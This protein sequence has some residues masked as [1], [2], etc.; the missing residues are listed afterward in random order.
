[1]WT[2]TT[3]ATNLIVTCTTI[4]AW[5]RRAIINIQLTI[6]PLKASSTMAAVCTDQ[7]VTGSAIL[8][9]CRFAF[10]YVHCAIAAG[11]SFQ[12]VTSVTVAY[13]LASSIVA[14]RLSA[15]SYT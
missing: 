7:I 15:Y 11:V 10:I 2:R 13:I 1:M 14:Q 9:G 4:L 5:I 6:L 12:A 3:E 8:T